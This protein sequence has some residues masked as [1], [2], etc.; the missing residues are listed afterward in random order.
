MGAKDGQ[1]SQFAS[2]WEK[3]EADIDHATEEEIKSKLVVTLVKMFLLR[4]HQMS[5]N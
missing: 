1:P 4:F 3:D 2:H 5:L